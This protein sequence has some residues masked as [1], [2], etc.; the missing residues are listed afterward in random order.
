MN[1]AKTKFKA[2]VCLLTV[3]INI[4]CVF[5]FVNM[6]DSCYIPSKSLSR[7]D[8]SSLLSKAKLDENDYSLLFK[9]TGLGRSAIDDLRNENNGTAEIQAIQCRYFSTVS[10]NSERLNPFTIEESVK[11]SKTDNNWLAPVRNGDILLTK[12][13]HTLYWRHGHCAIVIDAEK[14]IT[15]ESLEPGT[16]SMTQD[17]KKWQN[18]PTFKLLRLKNADRLTADRIAAYASNKLV[19][20]KYD[21]LASKSYRGQIPVSVNCSQLIW[22]TFYPFGFDLDS[23]KGVLVTPK[24]IAKSEL[25]EV[26]QVY[27]FNPDKAW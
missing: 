7:V 10:I 12:S 11:V 13:T 9:Q 27:G 25:L 14:G 21:V 22:R 3:I 8:L 20:L 4:Y 16:V 1:G 19:G 26:I 17:I 24:D 5:I 2:V 15:L 6:W 23:N 18:Y